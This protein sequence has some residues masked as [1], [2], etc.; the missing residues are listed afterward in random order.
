MELIFQGAAKA[1]ALLAAGDPEIWRIV[2]LSLRVSLTATAFSVLLGTGLGAGLALGRFPGRRLCI[3]LVNT[4]M[5]FP[6]VAAGLLVTIMLW[7]NGPL[8]DWELLYTP[9]AMIIAQTVIALPIVT[10]ISLSALQ[11]LPAGW[12]AQL[13]ALGASRRQMIWSLFKEARLP[14][15]AAVMAGFGGVISEVGASLMVGGNIK[16]STRVLTTAMVM[17]TGKGNFEIALALGL[18][19]LVLCFTVNALL[20][21]LQQQDRWS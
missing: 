7:R 20:T 4:G 11:Q 13:Y 17:E 14:L 12:P 3:V 16:G 15:L 1:L 18:I 21:W 8:G 10:G 2:W 6:P 19:L 9:A 5:G